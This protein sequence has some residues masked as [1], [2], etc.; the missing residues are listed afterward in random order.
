MKK[1]IGLLLVCICCLLPLF[2]GAEIFIEPCTNEFSATPGEFTRFE[3]AL[4]DGDY[5]DMYVEITDEYNTEILG[6][7]F[8]GFSEDE[9]GTYILYAVCTPVSDG[10]ATFNVVYSYTLDG[11]TQV[12]TYECIVYSGNAEPE[13]T[14]VPTTSPQSLTGQYSITISPGFKPATKL[15][16][17]KISLSGNYCTLGAVNYY[18]DGTA[19]SASYKPEGGETV[20]LDI[21]IQ[22]EA[23]YSF[24]PG[25]WQNVNVN[26]TDIILDDDECTESYLLVRVQLRVAGNVPVITKNPTAETVEAYGSCSFI[27]RATGASEIDWYFTDGGTDIVPASVAAKTFGGLK[28]SGYNDEKLQLSNIPPILDGYSVYAVFSNAEGETETTRAYLSV[29]T[30][31]D[32][33]PTPS[34][35]TLTGKYTVKITPGFKASTKLSATK[36]TVSGSKVSLGSVNYFVNGREQQASFKPSGGETV[37]L[38]IYIQAN[39]GYTFN[40]GS[41]QTVVVNGTEIDLD[42][43]ECTD[44]YLLVRVKLTVAGAP[45]T[46]TKNPTDEEVDEYGSCSFVARSSSDDA[47]ITW[48]FTDGENNPILASRA[49]KTFDGLKVTG[50][51]TEKLKLSNIPASL[52]GYSVYAVFTDDNGDTE[53]DWAYITVNAETTPAPRITA[54]PRPTNTPLPT[55]T[56]MPTNVPAGVTTPVPLYYATATPEVTE[57]PVHTHSFSLTKSYDGSYHYN[58]CSCGAKTN[59]AAHTFTETASGTKIIKKCS[60]CG[61]TVEEE[62]PA[63]TSSAAVILLIAVIVVLVVVVVLGIIYLK[64]EGRI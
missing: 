61:Y 43:D 29:S 25:S 30:E 35:K 11:E 38:E 2:A 52:D 54:T 4:L 33:T 49:Y 41:W 13:P 22:A 55:G 51:D 64:R 62:A 8:A 27:A 19:V 31:D 5:S 17:T 32:P 36:I 10:T 24:G 20:T 50:C 12:S 40:P 16:A 37:E 15:S 60:V 63:K 59:I 9:N 1:T 6:G 39:S 47:E 23:G 48:Y 53:T 3:L 34:G 45:P 44:D 56:P 28:V 21:Y 26:G 18:V 42:D 7:L 58:E 46:V 57:E 14:P